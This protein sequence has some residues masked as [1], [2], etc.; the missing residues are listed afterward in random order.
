MVQDVLDKSICPSLQTIQKTS[1]NNFG[2]AIDQMTWDMT[3]T[4]SKTEP[5]PMQY[6]C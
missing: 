5:L 3:E 2:N 4:E 1:L 6:P